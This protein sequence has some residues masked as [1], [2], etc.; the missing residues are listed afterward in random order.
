MKAW[1]RGLLFLLASA[2]LTACDNNT[3]MMKAVI[4][5]NNEAVTKMLGEGAEVD[6]RNNYGWTALMHASRQ[7]HVELMTL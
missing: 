1:G 4:D 3:P 6:A 2:M 5:E 7:G